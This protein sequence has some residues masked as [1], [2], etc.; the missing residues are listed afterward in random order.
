MGSMGFADVASSPLIWAK[1]LSVWITRL[2][3][4]ASLYLVDRRVLE[5]LTNQRRLAAHSIL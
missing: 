4:C 1:Y 5:C 2:P 3:D